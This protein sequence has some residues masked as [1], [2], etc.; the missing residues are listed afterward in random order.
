MKTPRKQTFISELSLYRI[1]KSRGLITT[2]SPI[3][4]STSDEFTD[5]YLI[6]P[7]SVVP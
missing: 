5:N 1:L 3:L 6:F 4:L 2:L 7:K